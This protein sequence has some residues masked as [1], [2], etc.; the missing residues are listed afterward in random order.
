MTQSARLL[1]IFEEVRQRDGILRCSDVFE[2]AGFPGCCDSCHEDA[3]YD[4]CYTL[5]EGRINPKLGNLDSEICCT[6]MTWL[7][8]KAV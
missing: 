3:E 1:E 8:E 7:E 5:H 2:V 6:V 4:N